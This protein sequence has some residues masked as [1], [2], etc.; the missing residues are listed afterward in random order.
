MK[1]KLIFSFLFVGIFYPAAA[2]AQTTYIVYPGIGGDFP[3]IQGC[4]DAVVDGD[5][6]EVY[7]ETYVENID[8]LGKL[9]TVRSSSD[10]S[11]TIIDGSA[12]NNSVV[13]F[14]SGE[15][16]D[17]VIEGF[18]LR[19]GRGERGVWCDGSIQYGGGIMVTDS[20][21][22]ISS[23]VIVNNII[24]GY[25]GARGA[26]IAICNGFP[27]IVDTIIAENYVETGWPTGGGIEISNYVVTPVNLINCVIINNGAGWC[28]GISTRGSTVVNLINCTVAWNAAE[29]EGGAICNSGDSAIIRNSIIWGNIS[30]VNPL[31]GPT[32]SYDIA[33]SNI[34]GGAAGP[35]N[36][37][38]DPIF[39]DPANGDYHLQAGSPCIDVGD[40]SALDL[41]PTD[42]DGDNRIINGDDVSGAVVDMGADEVVPEPPP[43]WGSA[44]TV[45]NNHDTKDLIC[46]DRANSMATIVFPLFGLFLI[47]VLK[48]K[49]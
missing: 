1:F 39:V 22:T 12:N 13:K 4:I 49:P 31:A 23:C 36:I 18:T 8:F 40:N 25:F 15:T 47:M 19:N 34:Q 6:C 42:I 45:L 5:T 11:D 27:T 28:G 17:S 10:P 7:P 38:Q 20:S 37:E 30:P 33:Y 29:H 3:T 2:L 35:G 14:V 44:S 41:P 43:P 9:I 32:S 48:R 46:S 26:G 24:N 16:E 21:P